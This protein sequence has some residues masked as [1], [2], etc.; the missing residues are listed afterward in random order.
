MLASQSSHRYFHYLSHVRNGRQSGGVCAFV[1]TVHIVGGAAKVKEYKSRFQ[2]S[3]QNLRHL[4]V[5]AWVC[6]CVW[7]GVPTCNNISTE[8]YNR[9]LGECQLQNPNRCRYRR[10]YRCMH[11]G[12][13]SRVTPTLQNDVQRPGVQRGQRTILSGR[14]NKGKSVSAVSFGTFGHARTTQQFSVRLSLLVHKRCISW[15]VVAVCLLLVRLPTEFYGPI[16]QVQ[17]P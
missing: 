10:D 3:A 9:I 2:R 7:V 14:C 11:S 16:Q 13:C 6:A 5:Y 4:S 8:R 17:C 15:C 1:C 12:C